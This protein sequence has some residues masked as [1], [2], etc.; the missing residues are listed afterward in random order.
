MNRNCPQNRLKRVPALLIL[1][2]GLLLAAGGVKAQGIP[3]DYEIEVLIKGTLA[4]FNDAN[5]SGDYTILHARSS[6]QVREQ[7]SAEKLSS[8]F[9]V[10]RDQQIDITPVLTL[11]PTLTQRPSI[12]GE[13]KLLLRGR[14]DTKSARERLGAVRYDN[15]AFDLDYIQSEGRWKMI[16]INVDVK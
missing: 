11:R 10:F 5:L 9:T 3:N 4:S 8:A 6:R 14:F 1:L 7:L 2:A 13:N 15:V 16:R 12:D